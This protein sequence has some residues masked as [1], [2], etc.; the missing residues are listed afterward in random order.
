MKAFEKTQSARYDWNLV[1]E[2]F[3]RDP[4]AGC[5]YCPKNLKPT[6]AN[7]IKEGDFQQKLAQGRVKAEDYI[8]LEPHLEKTLDK[9]VETVGD[10]FF[11]FD[12]Y[13]GVE[14]MESFE[15]LVEFL[16]IWQFL[17][18][19][20]LVL[21]VPQPLDGETVGLFFQRQ[22]RGNVPD[23]EGDKAGGVL[24]CSD[25]RYLTDGAYHLSRERLTIC[26]EFLGRR[27]YPAPGLKLFIQNRF[28][29]WDETAQSRALLAAWVAIAVSILIALAPYLSAFLT[30]ALSA[31]ENGKTQTTQSSAGEAGGQQAAHGEAANPLID[32][33]ILDNLE[34]DNI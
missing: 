12:L 6:P 21:E 11:F 25:R 30:E 28:R 2:A 1:R 24:R 27:V 15:G 33:I 7:R 23:P 4:E 13:S 19:Q 10:R 17:R 29:T 16:A 34:F 9:Q 18:E 8:R 3:S 20:A 22:P 32:Q 5:C 31:D 14:R 26:G